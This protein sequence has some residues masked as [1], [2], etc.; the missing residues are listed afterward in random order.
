MQGTAREPASRQSPIDRVEPKRLNAVPDRCRL[1]DPPHP[2]A[3]R[4]NQRL[5]DI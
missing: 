2:F 4:R 3:Q 5:C 1:F